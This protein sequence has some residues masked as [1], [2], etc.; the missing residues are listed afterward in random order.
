M[1]HRDLTPDE[2]NELWET[3]AKHKRWGCNCTPHVMWSDDPS[4]QTQVK[5]TIGGD[6]LIYIS[7]H[8]DCIAARLLASSWN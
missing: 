5:I 8:E 4:L 1:A 2:A 6:P 7:H 3:I